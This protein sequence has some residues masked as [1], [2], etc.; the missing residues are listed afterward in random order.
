MLWNI[1]RFRKN[2]WIMISFQSQPLNLPCFL[3]DFVFKQIRV[4]QEIRWLK[5]IYFI[6]W[7]EFTISPFKLISCLSLTPSVEDFQALL[8]DQ[9]LNFISTLV[10]IEMSKL[11]Y[12]GVFLGILKVFIIGILLLIYYADCMGSND[13]ALLLSPISF[14]IILFQ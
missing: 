3:I 14:H 6:S 5:Q 10:L 11:A 13:S 4:V 7:H 2:N 12:R 9:R 1:L 8:G